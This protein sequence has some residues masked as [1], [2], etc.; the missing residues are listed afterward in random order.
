MQMG[1][2]GGQGSQIGAT[3]D[4]L[5]G[6][7]PTGGAVSADDLCPISYYVDGLPYRG[8]GIDDFSPRVIEGIEL[9]NGPASTP[10]LFAKNGASCGVIVVWTRRW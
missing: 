3:R 1:G 6:A 2:L 4:D 10:P 7:G 5:G 9:Y 8:G